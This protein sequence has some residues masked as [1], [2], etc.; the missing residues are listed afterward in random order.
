MWR[1][2]EDL[3]AA[4]QPD[5]VTTHFSPLDMGEGGGWNESKGNLS[6][7]NSLNENRKKQDEKKR[8]NTGLSLCRGQ[9]RVRRERRDTNYI[10]DVRSPP[11]HRTARSTKREAVDR[12]VIL[13]QHGYKVA[14]GRTLLGKNCG[15]KV[16][17][18]L[19][20][21]SENRVNSQGPNFTA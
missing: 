9:T 10:V 17:S 1:T 16:R 7:N 19:S 21:D 13:M 20:T 2:H 3:Q 12:T 18:W 14:A 6:G 15:G 11:P 4:W 5:V 8:M